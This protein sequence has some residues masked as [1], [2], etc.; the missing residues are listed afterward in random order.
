MK[1]EIGDKIIVLH[2]DE[3]GVVVDFINDDMVMIEVRGVRFPA[4]MDQIDFPYFKLFTEQ[5]KVAKKKI[6]IDDIK[7]EKNFTKQKKEDGV[8]LNFVPIY[9]K[10]VFEDDV[11]EKLKVYLINQN[12]EAY[13]F[14]YRLLFLG[15]ENFSLKNTL[16]GLSMFY[17][18]DINFEDVSDNPKFEFEFSLKNPHKKKADFQEA[19]IK[20]NGKKLFKKIESLQENNEASFQYE[21]F[22]HY[23]DKIEIEKLDM[24]S[25]NKAG[26]RTS[27]EVGESRSY[28]PPARSVI[29]LHIDKIIDE[30][31]H[32]S[33]FEI[34]SIQLAEFEKYYDLA[35]QHKL[36]NFIVIHGVGVGKLRDEIHELLR[37]KKEVKSF[38]NQYHHLYGFGATEIIFN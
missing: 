11:V 30:Y 18:H 28:L 3:N 26:F 21:V 10:D 9:D 22:K 38:V 32:L 1:Y 35:V 25:L 27:Y 29:D 6:F 2:S 15:E 37:L 14:T 17:L 33:N 4:Y 24:S 7:P 13:N 5:R 36:N 23:P 20:V 16:E 19:F 8:F 34:L 12:E 31:K